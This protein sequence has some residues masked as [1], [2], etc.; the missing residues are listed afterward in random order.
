MEIIQIFQISALLIGTLAGA[1]TDYKTGYIYDWITIPM[2]IIGIGLSALAGQWNNL[3][4]GAAIFGGLYIFYWAGKIGGG[5]VKIFTAIA[6]L[7]PFNNYEFLLSAAFFAAIGAIIFYSTYYVL[8]YSKKGINWRENKNGLK[9]ATLLGILLIAYFTIGTFYGILNELSIITLG[10]PLFCGLIFFA[11]QKG[12]RKKF[13]I[14]KISISKLEEDEVISVEENPEKVLKIFKLGGAMA[15][16]VIG[17]KEIEKLKKAGV[18]NVYV[19]R[20]L[21][22]FGPF[23]FIGTALALAAPNFMTMLLI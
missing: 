10:F 19:L 14:K 15:K 12:I 1:T 13:F 11:F 18:K 2:I 8:K 7:N 3:L 17:E 5:D 20:D 16:G 22:P 6:L 4:I 21:P 23:I 9:Q